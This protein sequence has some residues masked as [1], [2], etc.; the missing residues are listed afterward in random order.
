[1]SAEAKIAELNLQLP[2]APKPAGVY[3]P[4]VIVGNLAYVSGHGPLKPDGTMMLGRVGSEVDQQAG[5]DAA[6]QTGLAILASLRVALGSLGGAL[7]ALERGA[8]DMAVGLQVVWQ[9]RSDKLRVVL[10]VGKELPPM[11]QSVGIAT[12]D[13]MRKNPDKLRK[14]IAARREAVQF[15][16]DK[17]EDAAKLT[18]KYFDKVAPSVL[19]KVT[20]DLVRSG[21][22]S[23]GRI[24]I[25]LESA[26]SGGP[27]L[28]IHDSGPGIPP[29]AR[30]LLFTP[31]YSS[32]RDGRGIGLTLVREILAQHRFPF[33]L[34]NG[35]AG[36]ATFSI[37]FRPQ[38]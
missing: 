18:E 31:F 2:P 26:A 21:Y 16:R 9:Q 11:V 15:M 25:A 19:A 13:L 27:A 7:T 36:G 5:Y 12:G 28:R 17:P 20:V 3:K 34:D 24:E 22:W 23:D 10:D 8:V 32:K 38:D 29:E 1:M 35:P 33:G 6:R 37:D 4:V 30:P 14:I